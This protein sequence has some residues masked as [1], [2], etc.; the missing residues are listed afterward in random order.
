ME[1][2]TTKRHP[3]YGAITVHRA[4]GDFDNLFQSSVGGNT[5]MVLEVYEAEVNDHGLGEDHVHPR[6]ELIEIHLSPLQWAEVISSISLGGGTPCTIHRIQGKM[7]EEP[8]KEEALAHRNARQYK[9]ELD[10]LAKFS[11][12]AEKLVG[13][14]LA[15]GGKMKAA[16]RDAL[17]EI[18]KKLT[19]TVTDSGPFLV[20]QTEQALSRMVEEAKATITDHAVHLRVGAGAV[21]VP[22][23]EAEVGAPSPT[24]AYDAEMELRAAEHRADQPEI[25]DLP[26]RAI[27][28][29]SPEDY[30]N[31]ELAEV[32][33]GHLARIEHEQQAARMVNYET[34]D[35]RCQDKEGA[36]PGQLYCAGASAG[37][38]K[39]HA[40]YI[41]YV[42]YHGTPRAISH[43]E[44]AAY[45][46]ALRQGYIGRHYAHEIQA[47][48]EEVGRRPEGT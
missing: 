47:W 32:I 23:L 1:E 11:K 24:D 12:R 4:T 10:D 33:S 15:K 14:I 27:E 48:T 28:Y 22:A 7:I 8:P 13:D 18:F 17:G 35:E 36:K 3:S 16:D 31:D 44:G 5:A 38:S 34:E 45:L 21:T 43:A 2:R 26:K 40:V 29:K 41:R 25:P 9:E 42:S 20:Q 19:R 30:S 37:A 46:R 6:K 39:K